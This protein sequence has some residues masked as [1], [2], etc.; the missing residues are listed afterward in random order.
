MG[1]QRKMGAR[2]WPLVAGGT[3]DVKAGYG[4][5]YPCR[6]RSLVDGR[7]LVLEVRPPLMTVIQTYDVEPTAAGA[8]IRHALEISGPLAGITQ[9]V[10]LDRVYQGW[11]QGASLAR[12]DA[13]GKLA[14]VLA[15]VL[16]IRAAAPWIDGPYLDEET[17]RSQFAT[18]RTAKLFVADGS[19][20]SD[21]IRRPSVALLEAI[22]DFVRDVRT[23]DAG[24]VWFAGPH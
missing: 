4:K 20:H 3:V 6:I 12:A 18:A 1:S 21:V 5:V 9:L 2:G 7:S 15:P 13:L 17:V 24:D 23:G 10:R 19:S 16:V 14:S 8:H 22:R 11:R